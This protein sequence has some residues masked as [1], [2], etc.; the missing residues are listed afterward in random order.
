MLHVFASGVAPYYHI[1]TLVLLLISL[2]VVL[3]VHLIETLKLQNLL[4]VYI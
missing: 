3:A 2:S 4:V 1:T